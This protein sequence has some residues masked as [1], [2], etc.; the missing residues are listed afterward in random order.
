MEREIHG[1][2]ASQRECVYE[3]DSLLCPWS[4]HVWLYRGGGE[5]ER[6]GEGGRKGGRES[7]RER[8]R[9]RDEDFS[10]WSF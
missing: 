4:I 8:E 5:I 3:R 1:G 6:V 7:E 10:L 9:M 2:I